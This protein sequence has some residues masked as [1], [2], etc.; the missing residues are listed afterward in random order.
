M[1]TNAVWF[2]CDLTKHGPNDYLLS[3][4]EVI[5]RCLSEF[6]GLI[7]HPMILPLVFADLERDRQADLV[8]ESRARLPQKLGDLGGND[9]D[10][11][12]P[13][14]SNGR[15]EHLETVHCS[16]VKQPHQRIASWFSGGAS[17][18]GGDSCDLDE[19]SDLPKQRPAAAS[20]AH[21]SRPQTNSSSV[22]LWTDVGYLRN[23]LAAWRAQ[24][25]KMAE[26]AEDIH[27]PVR[28][29]GVQWE[30]PKLRAWNETSNRIKDRL[31]ELLDEY[32]AHIRECTCIMDGLVLASQLVSKPSVLI[33]A[34]PLPDTS[35]RN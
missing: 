1:A 35:H 26:H 14:V 30:P 15:P 34:R 28:A 4:M 32:D 13:T 17:S 10:F 7:F 2:G 16:W 24:L 29:L 5:S 20:P 31:R 18:V 21:A 23:A 33:I 3:T 27:D 19:K 11:S 9:F 6:D 8:R 12:P 22:D 25:A